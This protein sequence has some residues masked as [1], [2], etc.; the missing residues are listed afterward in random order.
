M[1][2]QYSGLKQDR[3]RERHSTCLFYLSNKQTQHDTYTVK[4]EGNCV[5]LSS[6]GFVAL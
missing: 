5:I 2:I 6:S 1:L 3:E 4:T